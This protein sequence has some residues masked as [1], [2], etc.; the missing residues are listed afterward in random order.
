MVV[1]SLSAC[2]V[3]RFGLNC[4]EECKCVG[5][6]ECHPKTGECEC[7]KRVTGFVYSLI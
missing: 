3:G 6:K 5:C 4:T 1:T 7:E 2:S